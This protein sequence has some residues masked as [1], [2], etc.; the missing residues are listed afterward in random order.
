MNNKKIEYR[1]SITVD[2]KNGGKARCSAFLFET[3]PRGDVL[4]IRCRKCGTLHIVTTDEQGRIKVT[5]IK[6]G[7]TLM[8]KSPTEKE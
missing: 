3:N 8:T 4:K 7:N 2:K 5:G 6:K 1:C